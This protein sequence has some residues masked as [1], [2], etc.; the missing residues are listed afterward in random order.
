MISQ[1]VK[2][3]VWSQPLKHQ[4]RNCD[5]SHATQDLLSKMGAERHGRTI[6]QACTLEVVVVAPE[7]LQ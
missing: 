2:P 6:G 7:Q 1:L 5:G 4:E 3:L